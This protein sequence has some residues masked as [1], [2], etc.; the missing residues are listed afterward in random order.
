MT[1]SHENGKSDLGCTRKG[2]S[3][4]KRVNSMFFYKSEASLNK[5]ECSSSRPPSKR[6]QLK[7]GLVQ[8]GAS[9]MT[10]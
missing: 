6:T 1:K 9:K 5:A 4:G 10:R 3:K 7:A 2:I 8:N